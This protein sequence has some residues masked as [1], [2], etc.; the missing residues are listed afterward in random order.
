M[1]LELLFLGKTRTPYLA[2]GIDD[3]TR[4]LRHYTRLEIKT[5]REPR[6]RKN[7]PDSRLIE[8]ETKVLLAAVSKNSLVVALD[9]GGRPLSSEELAGRLTGWEGRG[10]KTASFLIG[11]ALGLAPSAVKAADLVLSLSAMTFTHEMARL[12]LVEQLYRAHTI[13]A[14]EKYHK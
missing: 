8:A 1:K 6:V 10:I 5:I 14:G 11:G 9:P 4:R 7:D 13:K 2:A 3:F 12:L